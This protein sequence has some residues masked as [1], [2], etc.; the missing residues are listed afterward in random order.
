M[1]AGNTEHFVPLLP[2]P[3]AAYTVNGHRR[4]PNAGSGAT[5]ETDNF[6]DVSLTIAV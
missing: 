6:M 3:P 1:T 4:F 5:Q 2:F